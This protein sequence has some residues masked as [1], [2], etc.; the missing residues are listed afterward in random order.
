MNRT[1]NQRFGKRGGGAQFRGDA[2]QQHRFPP[3]TRGDNQDVLARRRIDVPAENLKHDAKLA[4]PHHE[5]RDHLL[6]G[7]EGPRIEL[8]NLALGQGVHRAVLDSGSTRGLWWSRKR[9]DHQS[10]NKFD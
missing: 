4:V 1:G 9:A 10:F 5:L 6:V 7:L 8:A 3:A 2:R